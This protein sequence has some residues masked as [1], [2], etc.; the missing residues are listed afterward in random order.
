MK[1]FATVFTKTS[2]NCLKDGCLAMNCKAEKT[3]ADP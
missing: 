2:H 3:D 1:R